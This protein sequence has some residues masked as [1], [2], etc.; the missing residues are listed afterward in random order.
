VGHSGLPCSVLDLVNP[1]A[2]LGRTTV[3]RIR[4]DWGCVFPPIREPIARSRFFDF[5][6]LRSEG[7]GTEIFWRAD[8]GFR[9]P[10]APWQVHDLIRARRGTLEDRDWAGSTKK[11]LV[12]ILG[13]VTA[14]P[15]FSLAQC[16]T[17]LPQRGLD[18]QGESCP[19]KKR[20]SHE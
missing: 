2:I 20:S 1:G 4:M 10:D 12:F 14:L 9:T 16:A 11:R 8:A 19:L 18:M 13:V 7:R 17:L 3:R 15:H 6:A 5:A